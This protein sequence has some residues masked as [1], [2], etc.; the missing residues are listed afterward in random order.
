MARGC[1]TKLDFLLRYQQPSL[2]TNKSQER[3]CTDE[4]VLLE[5]CTIIEDHLKIFSDEMLKGFMWYI[6]TFFQYYIFT[7]VLWYLC[8]KPNSPNSTRAFKAIDDTFKV[9]GYGHN[10]G[11]KW[12]FILQLKAKAERP[13]ALSNSPDQSLVDTYGFACRQD[14]SVESE[15]P[16][17]FAGWDA[18]GQTDF[19]KWTNFTDEYGLWSL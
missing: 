18:A 10:H 15:I 7:S 5:A 13:R 11:L 2:E 8:I 1:L 16:S 9:Y 14:F 4:G 6:R 17:G 19:F 3:S 12:S